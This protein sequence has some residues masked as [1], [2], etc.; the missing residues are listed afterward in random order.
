MGT[1]KEGRGCLEAEEGDEAMR[2]QK[3]WPHKT[4]QATQRWKLAEE[5]NAP[6]QSF[7]CV[8][9]NEDTL[10]LDVKFPEL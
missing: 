3:W 4:E 6:P 7:L 2:I 8:R 1:E 5:W 10:T 9:G